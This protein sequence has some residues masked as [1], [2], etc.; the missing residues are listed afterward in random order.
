MSLDCSY[1]RSIYIL[2]RGFT[3]CIEHYNG[4]R[5]GLLYTHDDKVYIVYSRKEALLSVRISQVCH[6]EKKKKRRSWT[7]F[8]LALWRARTFLITRARIHIYTYKLRH[9]KTGMWTARAI[10]RFKC[11]TSNFASSYILYFSFFILFFFFF[12]PLIIIL[13]PSKTVAVR[14]TTNNHH[15]QSAIARGGC[16]YLLLRYLEHIKCT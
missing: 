16:R 10:E 8:N 7:N 4:R 11:T 12:L 6:Y 14:A 9:T 2:Y 15:H 3:K 13:T 5:N 1:M